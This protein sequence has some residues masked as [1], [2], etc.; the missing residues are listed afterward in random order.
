MSKTLQP[1]VEGR[2]LWIWSYF[3]IFIFWLGIKPKNLFQE[4]Y[5]HSCI[6]V[7]FWTLF[8]FRKGAS[9]L[10]VRCGLLSIRFRCSFWR[11]TSFRRLPLSLPLASPQKICE[12]ANLFVFSP[13]MAASLLVRCWVPARRLPPTLQLLAPTISS[14]TTATTI[15]AS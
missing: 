13:T 7:V 4:G 14:T 9:S 6:T 5:L 12:Y 15:P 11:F 1:W 2:N 3:C 10:V 8:L